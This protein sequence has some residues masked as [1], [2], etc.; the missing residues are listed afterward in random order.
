MQ[1]TF[2]SKVVVDFTSDKVEKK[3][4]INFVKA[5]VEISKPIDFTFLIYIIIAIVIILIARWIYEKS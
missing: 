3:V 2:D 5:P 1:G 4:V